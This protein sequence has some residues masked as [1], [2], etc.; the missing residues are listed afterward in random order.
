MRLRLHQLFTLDFK[1]FLLFFLSP[2]EVK[3]VSS[4]VIDF[5]V[6]TTRQ[7]KHVGK[8]L[9]S[10]DEAENSLESDEE[11]RKDK[12]KKISINQAEINSCDKNVIYY[13]LKSKENEAKLTWNWTLENDDENFFSNNEKSAI[14]FR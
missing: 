1:L 10:A 7:G 3:D 2:V 4:D 11:F 6:E 8:F 12:N 14:N 5:M 13:K 9:E